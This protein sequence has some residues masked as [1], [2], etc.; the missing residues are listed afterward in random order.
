MATT[1]RQAARM[2]SPIA[3]RLIRFLV[4]NFLV[5]LVCLTLLRIGFYAYFQAPDATVPLSTLV[6]AF[7]IGFKFDCRLILI[8]LLPVLLLGWIKPVN[9]FDTPRGRRIWV[10]YLT[11]V[12]SVVGLF[13]IFDF[14]YFAYLES[15]LDATILRFLYNLRESYR[16]VVES[17]PVWPILT[18]IILFTAGAG[19]GQFRLVSRFARRPSQKSRW[20]RIAVVTG[21]LLVYGFGIY[22]KLSW[23]P[24]RWSDAFFSNNA[25]VSAIALN[26]VLY[27][28][29]TLK[30]REV[31][32]DQEKV[33]AHYDR[34]AD[35]LGVAPK[36]KNHLSFVRRC[37]GPNPFSQPPN[38]IVVILESFGFYKTS[39]SGNPLDPTPHFD[40]LA[41]QG[42]LFTR[43][44]T[45]HGGTARSVFAA[46]SG[47]PDIELIKTSSRNPLVVRQHVIANEMKDYRKFYFLGGSASWGEIR[48]L[49][50][51]NIRDLSIYEEGSYAAPRVDV[52]GIS[53]LDLF[54]E[55]N[56]VL[57]TAGPEPFFA[58]I[59]TSGNHRP[60]TIPP[61]ND[62]FQPNPISDEMALRYG[63]RSADAYNS[64]RFMDHSIGRFI[65]IAQTEAYFDNTVFLFFGDHGLV[66]NAEHRPAYEHELIMNRYHVPLMIYAPKLMPSPQVIETV[67]SEVDVMPT[68][69]GMTGHPYLNTTFGRD[70]FD[71]RY[72][73]N[74]YAFTILHAPVPLLGLIGTDFYYNVKG[75]GSS[76]K[77]FKLDPEAPIE[78]VAAQYPTIAA[79]MQQL[80]LGLYESARYVRY[81]NTPEDVSRQSSHLTA[82]P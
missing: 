62:G 71:P 54:K 63:F 69:A 25:F 35:F 29:D 52:W 60:Y 59:Q 14:A 74:R 26:P 51:T 18:V 38:I 36:D 16:M 43:F 27:F 5:G 64:Y 81:H 57:K 56:A 39:L 3:P 45:P 46:V 68:I 77:L 75:D 65:D 32:Y 82:S 40:R 41:R 44:Y 50:S 53:D 67:A 4:F 80:C 11:I 70:L 48:G 13:Y 19:Y 33:A 24:L 6:N 78:N 21:F 61:N 79:K 8:A 10:A 31:A 1:I 7:F 49:L 76:P 23:Y 55:A 20:W 66:R 47:I 17:Y 34:I 73:K 12:A 42:T 72:A 9:L 37:T 30:N 15:R 22:G 58:I 2:K 28:Y